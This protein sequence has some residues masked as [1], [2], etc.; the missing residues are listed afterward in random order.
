MKYSKA[1][2][3][4]AVELSARELVEMSLQD[5][6][7]FILLAHNHLSDTALP[8]RIDVETTDRIRE[9]L[10]YVGV[11]LF[12]HIIVCDGDF[13]SMRDSGYFVRD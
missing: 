1:A 11:G 13:V 2:V 8:S 5:K 7:A 9:A 3:Q 10:A 12:D 4:A 6:A